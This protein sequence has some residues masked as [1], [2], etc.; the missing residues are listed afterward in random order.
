MESPTKEAGFV[1]GAALAAACE[2]L[3][4][5]FLLRLFGFTEE[6]LWAREGGGGAAALSLFTD[7]TPGTSNG[8]GM[9]SPCFR[10]NVF[11]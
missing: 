11:D 5:A 2:A 9:V 10:G 4:F 1:L 6:V 8:V 7:G 3:S